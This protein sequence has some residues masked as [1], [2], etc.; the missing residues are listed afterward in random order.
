MDDIGLSILN[1]IFFNKKNRERYRI[2][3][4]TISPQ[5]EA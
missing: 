2:K 1:K 3:M 4:T 5:L